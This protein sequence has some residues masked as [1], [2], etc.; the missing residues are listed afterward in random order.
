MTN[1]VLRSQISE[2]KDSK[3]ILT[4]NNYLDNDLPLE[5]MVRT[6]KVGNKNATSYYNQY[7]QHRK[8]EF[9]NNKLRIMGNSYSYGMDLSKSKDVERKIIFE[10]TKTF[11]K[12]TYDLGYIDNGMYAVGNTLND[13]FDKTRAWFDK[14]IDISNIKEGNYAIY[15]TNKS[16][17][18]DYGELNE[19]LLRDLS[20][21]K[22]TINGKTY[23]FSVNNSQRYRIE[24]NVK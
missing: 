7:N 22:A 24:L 3:Y 20:S 12:Y 10:N 16:N 18:E 4:R 6:N 8:L 1:K 17:I 11:E 9:T 19:L 21:I 23:S 2:Y 13:N 5:I 14:T 15:I